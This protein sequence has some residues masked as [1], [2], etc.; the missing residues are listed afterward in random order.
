MKNI[1]I[2]FVGGG[3]R[4]S[5]AEKLVQSGKEMG[6]Y[7]EIYAYE[8]GVGLPIADIATVIQGKSFAEQDVLFDLEQK[9]LELNIDIALPYHD[10]AILLL[11]KLSHV[12]FVPTCNIELIQIFGSKIQSSDFFR[13]HEIPVPPFSGRAPSIAKPNFGSASKGLLAFTK[14]DELDLFLRSSERFD[15]EIQDFL[16]G[17]EYSVDGYIAINSEFSYFAVRERIETLGGEVIRSQ[18]LAI[19]EIEAYCQKIAKIDKVR[20]AIT[21]QFIFDDRSNSY[22]IMEINPR[23]GG[24]ML[25]TLGAGVPWFKIL[26]CDYF[27]IPQLKV[28]HKNGVLMVR[29]F[30]EHFFKFN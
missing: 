18:T 10:S 29:S 26:L 24:G 15:Y 4:F 30:R 7:V 20:G 11:A 14:Q 13:N 8:M 22:K 12:V 21:L 16:S 5:A 27:K 3:K 6:F 19:T 9:I 23:F 28:S 2:L 25:T 1:R 17:P